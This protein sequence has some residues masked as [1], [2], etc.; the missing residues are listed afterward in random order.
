EGVGDDH[1]SRFQH[2]SFYRDCEVSAGVIDKGRR[3]QDRDRH[4]THMTTTIIGSAMPKASL[5]GYAPKTARVM[6]STAWVSTYKV[7]W[8]RRCFTFDILSVLD[9]AMADGGV[10][11]YYRD[12]LS[13]A[14]FE[15]MDAGVFVVCSVG[16]AGPDPIS[17]TNVSPWITTVGESSK[18]RDLPASVE[19]R[20]SLN[21][22][23]V[24][25]YKGHRNLSL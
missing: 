21:K 1:G 16:N 17:L 7:Y 3:P 5:L 2:H 11:S 6:A 15:A 12:S 18:D 22:T 9:R 8:P 19:L 25:L 14:A 4:G 10:S 23:G 24:S 20:S 13:V